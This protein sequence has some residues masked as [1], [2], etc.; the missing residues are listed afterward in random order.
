MEDSELN[1]LLQEVR[2]CLMPTQ[3]IEDMFNLTFD[4]ER[5]EYPANGKGSWT[6]S[7]HKVDSNQ[8]G[9]LDDG[10]QQA[11]I[12]TAGPQRI[13]AIQSALYCKGNVEIQRGD[14]VTLKV[15]ESDKTLPFEVLAV[16]N[17]LL[18]FRYLVVYC[19]PERRR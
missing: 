15:D 8:R 5:P 12:K 7:W 3:N 18:R 4:V 10:C 16:R 1:A 9:A 11:Q 6:T 2:N 19:E 14:S 17:P 13:E